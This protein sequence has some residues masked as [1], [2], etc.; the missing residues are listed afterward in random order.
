MNDKPALEKNKSDD[1]ELS[2]F[3]RLLGRILTKI[4][5]AIAWVFINLYDLLILFFL[6]IKRKIVWLALGFVLGSGFGLFS[7]YNSGPVYKSEM[8]TK[9]NFESNYFLYNQVD[10]FNSL[11]RNN[12]FNEISKIFNISEAEAKELVGFTALPVKN[13]IEA[14]KLYRQTFLQSKR[15]HN[16]GFDTIWSR[17]LKFD[18]FKRQLSDFDYP[19][20]RIIARSKQADIFPKIQQGILNSFNNN[21]ELKEKKESLQEIRKQE[22]T[23]LA[24]VLKNIDTLRQVYNKKLNRQAE[25]IPAAGG[26]QFILGERE[27]RNPELDLYDKSMIVKDELIELRMKAAEEKEPLVL[28]SGLGNTGT[29]ESFRREIGTPALYFLAAVFIILVMIEFTK[30]LIKI[31]K[32][33]KG[34]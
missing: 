20:N 8:V 18:A 21:P 11:I 26:N 16:Y 2:D 33:K 13:D 15:N 4:G 31:E 10:Y 19:V 6:F 9:S 32:I 28:F 1:V 14:A 29:R 7:Y 3:L 27:T 17:T 25:S 12:K 5:N 22:E 24:D 30:Y 34:E 23:L